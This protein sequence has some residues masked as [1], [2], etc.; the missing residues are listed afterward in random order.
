MIHFEQQQQQFRTN[1]HRQIR[2]YVL[3]YV[4]I[5]C[6]AQAINLIIFIRLHASKGLSMY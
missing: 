4:Y 3:Q 2:T 1:T 6:A 5:G